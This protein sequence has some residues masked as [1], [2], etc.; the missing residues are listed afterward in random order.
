[1]EAQALHQPNRRA[2][3]RQRTLLA[4][5]IVH[6]QTF[7][8]IEGVV[9]N[10]S[11]SGAR[12]RLQREAPIPDQVL[13]LLVKAGELYEANV[14]WRTESEVGLRFLRTL[15]LTDTTDQNV[16][17]LRQLW[18]ALAGFGDDQS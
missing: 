14:A 13:L 4:C 16:R 5:R 6:G 17:V 2:E 8:S 12:V 3:P 11:A 15:S 7:I 9:R 1:M 18:L 10:L